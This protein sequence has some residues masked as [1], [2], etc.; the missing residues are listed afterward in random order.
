MIVT[1]GKI[2]RVETGDYLLEK[3]SETPGRVTLQDRRLK[4]RIHLP[5]NQE[6]AEALV[7]AYLRVV[8]EDVGY[9]KMECE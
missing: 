4:T 8:E 5:G 9:R 7:K 6:I 3:T 2:I 1:T